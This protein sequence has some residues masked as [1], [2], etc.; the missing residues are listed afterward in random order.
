MLL[1]VVMLAITGVSCVDSDPGEGETPDFTTE[2][3][4]ADCEGDACSDVPAAAG[5][6]CETGYCDGAGA[7]ATCADDQAGSAQDSG[8]SPALPLCDDGQCVSCVAD[9]DCSFG[10]CEGGECVGCESDSDCD[11]GLA[12]TSAS[13]NQANGRCEVE[14]DDS[15]CD[16]GLY[17]NGEER[18]EPTAAEANAD[19]C[20][21][22]AT[23][24]TSD[25]VFCTRDRCDES[26]D[27]LLHEPDD[28][29]CNGEN[30][31]VV[32]SCDPSEGCSFENVADGTLCNL[33]SDVCVA[34]D[35]V[36]CVDEGPGVDPGC[37]GPTPACVAEVCVQC[38]EETPC[39]AGLTC[40]EGVCEGCAENSDCDD[41]VACTIDTCNATSQQCEYRF[42]DVA[43][44]NADA[45]DGS[46]VCLPSS[47]SADAAGCAVEPGPVIDD[48]V[49][50]TVDSCEPSTGIV[51][52]APDS[53]ACD[54]AGP[55]ARAVCTEEGCD[56]VPRA[57][58]ASCPA[59]VCDGQGACG[60][61]ADTEPFGVDAGCSEESPSCVDGSCV[62]CAEEGPGCPL[63]CAGVPGGSSYEDLCGVCDDDP[64]NDCVASC[65]DRP[66]GS[67]T[68]TPCDDD[69]TCDDGNPCTADSC[70][71]GFCV[72]D[73]TPL[74]GESCPSFGVCVAEAV[75]ADG[76]CV[77]DERIDC[78]GPCQSGT[79]LD[80][81][82]CL[83]QALIGESCDD[84][85]PDT[86]NDVC[87]ALG[88]CAGECAGPGGVPC[89]ESDG[90]PCT[91]PTCDEG[92][93]CMEVPVAEG[94][95]CEGPCGAGLCDDSGSCEPLPNVCNPEELRECAF[96][97]CRPEEGGCVVVSGD[98]ACDQPGFV[99]HPDD[100]WHCH[101]SYCTD[102]FCD[103]D[104]AF[105]EDYFRC[106]QDCPTMP[107]GCTAADIVGETPSS[108]SCSDTYRSVRW[109]AAHRAA[110]SRAYGF[111]VDSSRQSATITEMLES[112]VGWLHL[113]VDYC[114]PG[115][116]SGELC[117]CVGDDTCSFESTPLDERLEEVR[118]Y[119]ANNP[120]R[121]VTLYFQE[122]V[123][124]SD[125]RGAVQDADLEQYVY[126]VRSRGGFIDPLDRELGDMIYDGE[127]LVIIGGNY[128]S[129]NHVFLGSQVAEAD[130]PDDPG[131][132]GLFKDPNT[133]Y[134]YNCADT[135]GRTP[136]DLAT[137]PRIYAVL[138][139]EDPTSA[140]WVGA[141]C[142]ARFL[143]DHNDF[144][145]ERY[146]EPTVYFVNHYNSHPWPLEY[147]GVDNDYFNSCPGDPNRPVDCDSDEDC[148]GG[149]CN[150]FGV[151][152][153]CLDNSDCEESQYCDGWLGACLPDQP[154]GSPCLNDE[155][156]ASNFCELICQDCSSNADC[157]DNE[158]CDAFG[159]CQRKRDNGG[160]CLTGVECFSGNCY[161]GY[162]VACNEQSDC[163]SPAFCTLDPL[164]GASTCIDPKPI[165]ETCAQNF[166]CASGD[167]YL[168]FCVECNE[169][170]DCPDSGEFCS[171]N[172]APGASECI[173]LK[174]NSL[175]CAQNFECVSGNCYLGFCVECNEQSDCTAPAFCS[176]D[177]GP[178][179]SECIDPKPDGA[180]CAQN[181]ECASGNCYLGFCVECNEQSDCP[182]SAEFCS[183]S[184]APGES[185]CI[186]R[187]D[188]GA[189]CAQN[190]ECASGNCYLGFCVEC[191]E[192]GDC[193]DGGEFCSLDPAPAASACIPRKPNGEACAQAFECASGACTAF[194]CG[195]C[196]TDANCP[197]N[198][199]CDAFNNCAADVGNGA[200]CLKDSACTTAICLD[201]FCAQCRNDGDCS[202]SQHCDAFNNCVADVGNGAPCLRDSACTTDLCLAGFCAQCETDAGCPASQHCDAV[203]NCVNDVPNG[204]P[205][206]RD[207]VCDTDICLAGFC[208]QCRGH[209][210]CPASQHC[211]AFS[212]CVNDV[213]N[214]APCTQNEQCSTGICSAGFCAQC[215]NDS[216]CSSSQF[217]NVG[218][219]CE[220][221][222]PNGSPCLDSRVCQSGC[223]GLG[224]CGGPGC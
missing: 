110:Q 131:F 212:N 31:C 183:L 221:K 155:D 62:A 121:I 87:D 40:N 64:T 30:E 112:G 149:A 135:V 65:V 105:G 222:V 224:F 95:T 42:N 12:C 175:P 78:S 115:A 199:H 74:D 32:G 181:F 100:N 217:C 161:L 196:A 27:E 126:N 120:F 90:N 5:V 111:S 193:P 58:G 97:E 24:T 98:P 4:V 194:V 92:G 160:G 86:I 128:L 54:D 116:N 81:I 3:M 52:N 169:Q 14:R 41:G 49:D 82:G 141:A 197:A 152:V 165:G 204:S 187:K 190:L 150:I 93:G 56:A 134:V 144:C 146:R 9:S 51:T 47:A 167:C 143:D 123:N 72:N 79:C 176:L 109:L 220:N 192:Q 25:D 213:G 104:S 19:G 117:I 205:C 207:S 189:V 88:R 147:V 103:W 101:G 200:P 108:S 83:T 162:C 11:D 89:A 96:R 16:D 151:C 102:G 76:A 209:G 17:C 48:G 66:G 188:N 23:F 182:G 198:E 70:S 107:Q 18:C 55:C 127:R 22:A 137:A 171:L 202:E 91:V 179:A 113:V 29:L 37:G 10:S 61:C 114:V 69:A 8:C 214:N 118:S 44:D 50:C 77:E 208:A 75:C 223:C 142:W 28:A 185:A 203:N 211:D 124:D 38:D 94:T 133:E 129:R 180:V 164:P 99:C 178:G 39:A 7:C 15:A 43:C 201:G 80:G 45:C 132:S 46:E 59:G 6:P 139:D 191:N 184:P 195:E 67:S 216:H 177:P 57:A 170:S 119:L 13:C 21:R 157:D 172:P 1:L 35:C 206:L 26:T 20:V 210:D 148:E 122:Y 158:Y 174:E 53:D 60:T 218:G 186:P 219:D 138:H 163:E 68:C 84:G 166:E 36:A 63:D 153:G 130:E 156:C 159:G 34:G 85:D 173:P 33:E 2:C 73:G 71:E 125:L 215:T 136:D 154:T 145:E 168:G 140:R 106:P